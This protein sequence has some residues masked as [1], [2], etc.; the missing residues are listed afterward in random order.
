MD[1]SA[2]DV[3]RINSFLQERLRSEGQTEVRA[4]QAAQ[5][6]DEARLL[7]DSETRRGK[8]LRD[9]MRSGL[10]KG[11]YQESGRWWQ[12]R[13]IQLSQVRVST[14]KRRVPSRKASSARDHFLGT[15]STAEHARAAGFTG[16]VTV[17]E[18]MKRGLPS[19]DPSSTSGVYLLCAPPGFRP[20]IIPPDEARERGNVFFPWPTEP[21]AQ[22][23]VGDAEIV[24][25]G[26]STNLRRRLRELIRHAQGRT[27]NHTGGEI[28]WQL[29]GSERLIVC[30]RRAERPR[31]FESS[32]IQSFK[33]SHKGKLPFANRQV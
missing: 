22:K 1:Y 29:R 20:E 11:A 5:W 16:F 17:G 21:L 19:R 14:P 9:L 24:Y 15:I 2:P 12:I 30:W 25:I 13:Q 10:I 32:L 7:K 6:L 33:S 31:E 4:V 23:W 28:V 27:T 8:P 18:C 3:K 26:K